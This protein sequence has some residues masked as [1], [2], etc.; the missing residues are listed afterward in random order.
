M[1][2]NRSS[3]DEFIRFEKYGE[4]ERAARFF[5]QSDAVRR[6]GGEAR[7]PRIR[8]DNIDFCD[9]AARREFAYTREYIVYMHRK[10]YLFYK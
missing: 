8:G 9:Y 6:D 7:D 2:A 1:A 5:G 3:I 10:Y 4:R